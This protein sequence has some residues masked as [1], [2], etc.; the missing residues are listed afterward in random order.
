MI[1]KMSNYPSDTR[2]IIIRSSDSGFVNML[3]NLLTQNEPFSATDEDINALPI[4]KSNKEDTCAIC[5]ENYTDE[6]SELPCK[7][8]F[9]T[10]C[11]HVWLKR[12]G[13]CPV[14]RQPI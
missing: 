9:H 12:R 3:Y 14:C 1:N 5:L 2:V 6:A 8:I 4:V 11:I 7:H 13:I 10:Q